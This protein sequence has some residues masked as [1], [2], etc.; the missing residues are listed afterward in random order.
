[1]FRP[2]FQ[3]LAQTTEQRSEQSSD[4][5]QL[6]CLV[7]KIPPRRMRLLSSKSDK[8]VLSYEMKCVVILVFVRVGRAPRKLTLSQDANWSQ[9]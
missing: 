5:M 3:K 6:Y 9:G 2:L 1:M 8:P 4:L 7:Q